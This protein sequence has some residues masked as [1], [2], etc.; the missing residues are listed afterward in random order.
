MVM[1]I[2]YARREMKLIRNKS[3]KYN[4]MYV[5]NKMRKL[6]FPFII[7]IVTHITYQGRKVYYFIPRVKFKKF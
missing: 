6:R 1:V 4:P 5:Y 2:K 3:K 7:T